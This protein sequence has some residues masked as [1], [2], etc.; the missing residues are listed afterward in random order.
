MRSTA[1][2][3]VHTVTTAFLI[4][5]IIL[6][7]HVAGWA[8]ELKALS[9]ST[10]APQGFSWRYF[11][12]IHAKFLVP[13]GWFVKEG[14]KVVDTRA[15]FISEE[16]IEKEGMFH[17]GL[18]VNVTP[19][20]DKKSGMQASDYALMRFNDFLS[21]SVRTW[22]K[23]LNVKTYGPYSFHD[24]SAFSVVETSFGSVTR[25]LLV[26][27]NDQTG[28]LY[29]FCFESPESLWEESSKVGRTIMDNLGLDPEF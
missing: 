27:S 26:R 3:W 23:V 22:T 9:A 29:I 8:E 10:P 5:G 25:Y 1:Q 20:V 19:Q 11:K 7:Q 16:S 13:D 15:V 4:C 21:G 24:Y 28:T 18:T 6:F 14:D 17:T 2:R 12:D